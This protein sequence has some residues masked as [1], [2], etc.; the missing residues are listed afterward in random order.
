[1]TISTQ[2]QEISWSAFFRHFRLFPLTKKKNSHGGRIL[3]NQEK[4]KATHIIHDTWEVPETALL[5][6]ILCI[7][8]RILG[9]Q[10]QIIKYILKNKQKTEDNLF[11]LDLDNALCD[12]DRIPM[13]V[14]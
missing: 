6:S 3:R 7:E 2:L 11:S 10:S 9:R 13:H 5:V 12:F 4:S 14:T 1:M 8:A